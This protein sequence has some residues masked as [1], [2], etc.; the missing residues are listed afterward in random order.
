[1]AV[2][3]VLFLSWL[4]FRAAGGLGVHVFGTWQSSAS[5]ALAVLF[6]FTAITHF[7]S[8]RH[9]MA[10]MVP[11]AFPNPM[12]LVY[13]TGVFEGLGAIGLLFPQFR[14]AAAL[15]LILLLVALF[16]ANVKA[17]RQRLTLRGKPATPLP[18]RLPMQLLFIA[19]LWW[20][21]LH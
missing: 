4:A 17:A 9:D 14:F 11:S 5:Y 12:L 21:C 19:L 10:R 8:I 7:T 1:M 20:S 6:L 18:L 15:G 13:V 3:I 16:P 2:L